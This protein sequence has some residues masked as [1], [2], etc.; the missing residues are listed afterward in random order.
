MLPKNND[1]L[2]NEGLSDRFEKWLTVDHVR[3]RYHEEVL[4]A[5]RIKRGITLS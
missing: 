2:T 5:S 3:I 4:E 1:L